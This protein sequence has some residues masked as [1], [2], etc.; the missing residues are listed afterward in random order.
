MKQMKVLDA[1]AAV[2]MR[3][4]GVA[5]VMANPV[6]GTGN[7]QVLIS[8][9]LFGGQLNTPLSPRGNVLNA[10]KGFFTSQNKKNATKSQPPEIIDLAT[11]VDPHLVSAGAQGFK[12][13]NRTLLRTY[14]KHCW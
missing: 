4:D 14:L 10:F 9:T 5:A 13:D 3:E 12:L 1:L 6:N 2:V 11:L 7:V 8:N